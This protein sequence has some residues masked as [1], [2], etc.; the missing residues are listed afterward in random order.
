M[1]QDTNWKSSIHRFFHMVTVPFQH[2]EYNGICNVIMYIRYSPHATSHSRAIALEQ[3]L[4]VVRAFTRF[5]SSAHVF[6]PERMLSSLVNTR[7]HWQSRV[8]ALVSR[9]DFWRLFNAGAT[10]KICW[11]LKWQCVYKPRVPTYSSQ[12]CSHDLQ[13]YVNR[14]TPKTCLLIGLSQA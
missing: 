14:V 7:T 6:E 3:A 2:M 10:G 11:N 9:N 12:V 13:S 4:V 1:I 8:N 5:I